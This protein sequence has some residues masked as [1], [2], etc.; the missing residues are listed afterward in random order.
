[1][2]ADLRPSHTAAITKTI[3]MQRE[4]I[5]LVELL[6]EEY[7]HARSTNVMRSPCVFNRSRYRCSGTGPLLG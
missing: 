4:R 5:L 6:H 7:A 2:A 1:M 3:T